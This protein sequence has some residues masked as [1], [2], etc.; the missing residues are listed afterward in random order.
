[1]MAVTVGTS[2]RLASSDI[3]F[4]ANSLKE[5]IAG[6]AKEPAWQMPLSESFQRG[7]ELAAC[8]KHK[9]PPAQVVWV[10]LMAVLYGA[11]EHGV[12]LPPPQT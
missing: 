12:L 7:C 1:M 9:S 5:E 11:W 3:A 4:W 8:Y 2:S 6:T 10:R